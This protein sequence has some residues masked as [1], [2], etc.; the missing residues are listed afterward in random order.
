MGFWGSFK[1]TLFSPFSWHVPLKFSSASAGSVSA[2]TV[3]C[4]APRTAPHT[5]MSAAAASA[6]R[7]PSGDQYMGD[8][9]VQQ[10]VL[11]RPKPEIQTALIRHNISFSRTVPHLILAHHA[12]AHASCC[13]GADRNCKKRLIPPDGPVGNDLPCIC[14]LYTS[15]SRTINRWGSF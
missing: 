12:Q 15:F 9:S 7:R 1:E 3:G 11:S 10:P 8:C 6:S 2:V 13:Q 4:A 14:L 5:H